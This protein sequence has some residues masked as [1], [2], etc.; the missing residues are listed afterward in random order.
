MTIV[1][2]AILIGLVGAYTI[3]TM[4][5]PVPPPPP[6][7]AVP[8]IEVPLA[9]SD[10]PAHRVIT[11]GD[12]SLVP[13]SPEQLRASGF[14]LAATMLSSQQII[15]RRLKE[16]LSQGR[17]FLTTSLYLEGTAPTIS[18]WLKPGYRAVT[19]PL[20]ADRQDIVSSGTD[21]DVLFLTRP[22]AYVPE[23]TVTFVEG[24]K[25][26]GASRGVATLEVTYEDARRIETVQG[27]GVFSL[28]PRSAA[29][30]VSLVGL[31]SSGRGDRL[32]F[33]EVLG[34]TFP[35]PPP[36]PVATEI[37][38]GGQRSVNMFAPTQVAVAKSVEDLELFPYTPPPPVRT[39][40]SQQDS[41]GA[42]TPPAGSSSV[43]DPGSGGAAATSTP[44]SQRGLIDASVGDQ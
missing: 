34:I 7:R 27:K 13:M 20:A 12:I 32:T 9:S 21:V 36:S 8:P 24:A 28:V 18:E 29:E 10:L 4:L 17:P 23:M 44:D 3:R 40:S 5:V 33:N 1:I 31:A 42:I 14:P 43:G 6:P 11:L 19:V 2:L 22:Q 38:R 39:R 30:H 25:V 35:P 16:P 26:L 37:Y 41:S 15:G